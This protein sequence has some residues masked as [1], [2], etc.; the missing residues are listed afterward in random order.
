MDEK[1]VTYRNLKKGQKIN[2]VCNGGTTSSFIGYVK[3]FN[4]AFVTVEMW[5]IGGKEERYD[6][7]S[8]FFIELT[9]EEFEEKY[10]EKAKEI[11]KNIQ[12]KISA[13]TKGYHEMWNGWLYGTPYEMAKACIENNINIVGH[14]YLAIPKHGLIDGDILDMGICAENED[15]EKFWCHFSKKFYDRII[16]RY[17]KDLE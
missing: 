11:Y 12:N 8:M 15:G 3:D 14:S 17:K 2:G 10:K 9:E 13:D 1:K 4:P 7:D 5:K 6:S 16:N